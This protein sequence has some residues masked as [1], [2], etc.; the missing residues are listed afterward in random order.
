MPAGV[1]PYLVKRGRWS[2][3]P[4]EQVSPIEHETR[5]LVRRALTSD[6][7]DRL[8]AAASAERS[9][10]YRQALTTGLRRSEIAPSPGET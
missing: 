5:P 7:A 10:I 8:L 2:V 3:N 4:V 6:E 1:L 9:P